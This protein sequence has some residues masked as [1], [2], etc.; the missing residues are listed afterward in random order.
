KPVA[1]KLPGQVCL[2]A[3]KD[4]WVSTTLD[5]LGNYSATVPVGKYEIGLYDTYY[6]TDDHV[7]GTMQQK[8]V[9]VNVKAAQ[10]TTAREVIIP[11]SPVPDLL[12]EKGILFDLTSANTDQV[13]NFIETYMKYYSI[14]GV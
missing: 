14:P 6:R 13:D 8:P 1:V 4:L 7:Y 3:N 5:S 11:S 9:T 10:N 12:P 2:I